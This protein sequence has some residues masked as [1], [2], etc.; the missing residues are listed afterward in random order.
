ARVLPEERARLLERKSLDL[1]LDEAY[2]SDS[3]SALAIQ[4]LIQSQGGD[5]D[6]PVRE[7]ILRMHHYTQTLRDPA[8]W[9]AEQTARFQEREPALWLAWLMDELP[10]WRD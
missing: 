8:R 10:R 3:L 7:L 1:V 5:W 6:L 4:Q 9:F 2:S